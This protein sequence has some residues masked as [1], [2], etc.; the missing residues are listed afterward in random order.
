M[1]VKLTPEKLRLTCINLSEEISRGDDF[2]SNKDVTIFNSSIIQIKQSSNLLIA[3]RGWYGDVRSWSGINFVIISLFN[4]ELKKIKQNILNI[5]PK[6]VE[7]KKLKFKKLEE[8]IITH[9]DSLSVGPEDPRLFYRDNDI[10]I[11]IN[12]LNDKKQRH[13]FVA[14]I[15]IDNL[16]YGSKIEICKS[17]ST[18]FEKNWGPFIYKDKL[19]MIY[20]INPL[21]VLEFDKDFNCKLKMSVKDA[22]LTKFNKSY[23]DL[24][25]H[26]RNSTNLIDIGNNAFLGMGHCVLDYKGN[27]EINK[28]LIPSFDDSKYSK[29]D[30]AYFKKFFKLYTGFF[31]KLDM[32]KNEITEISP[33]FQLPNYESK[34]ELIFF[35]TSIYL[36][37]DKF[38]NISYNVG[39]NRSYYLK[40]HLDVINI[41]LYQKATI[42][43]QMNHNIN[44]NYYIE[45]VRSIRKVLGYPLE[46]KDYYRFGDVNR[47]YASKKKNLS[48]R[49]KKSK[50]RRSKKSK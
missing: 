11:L 6:A 21:K 47:I 17:L 32:N 5:D 46:K 15:D 37:K 23:P 48:N 16:T 1:E 29:E 26:I 40:L 44:A 4:K 35:P 12:E 50:K 9:A 25:F 30:K 38:V 22:L 13:M 33:F 19:H 43:F 45:L 28:Y 49:Q 14:K 39:D 20:D 41:S 18:D 2:L 7:N 31:Y 10:Y 3:S 34:Q 8:K 27:T 24:H 42:D 36:D